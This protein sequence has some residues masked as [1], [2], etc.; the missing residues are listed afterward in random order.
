[1]GI[2]AIKAN[3]F[4]YDS[5]ETHDRANNFR[6]YD[7]KQ[8]EVFKT[9]LYAGEVEKMPCPNNLD[10]DCF[11]PRCVLIRKRDEMDKAG[12]NEKYQKPQY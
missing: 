4:M 12:L 3:N 1:M 11:C 8:R 7:N 10:P 6:Y 9:H 2:K 5:M